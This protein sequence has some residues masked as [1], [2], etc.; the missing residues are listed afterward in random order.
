[1]PETDWAALD[2]MIRAVLREHDGAAKLADFVTVGI[3]GKQMASALHRGVVERPRSGWYVDPAIPW[4]AKCAIRVGGV[5]SRA[6]ALDSFG[7]P[8]PPGAADTMEVLVPGNC[9]RRRHSR[10][11]RRYV[12]PGEDDRVRLRWSEFDG[13]QRGW[14]TG[15]VETL[16]ATSLLL[17]AEWWVA[18][19]DAARHASREGAVL[20]SEEGFEDLR[21]RLAPERRRLLDLV[22]PRAESCLETLLRLG[23]L[24]RGIEPVTPQFSPDGVRRVDFLVGDRLIVEADGA[25]F[26]DEVRDALRDAEWRQRGYRVLRFSY[27][28]IVHD[29]DAVLDEIAAALSVL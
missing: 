23:M 10:D 5:L 12:V 19:V 26:H 3:T 15:L 22:D 29:L 27:D 6:S 13:R 18:A 16:L 14:K 20:L 28:R 25:A 8:V 9:P 17:P 2:V 4:Q 1:M 24:R 7:L 11:R 21:W